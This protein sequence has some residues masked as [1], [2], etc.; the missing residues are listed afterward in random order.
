MVN[1]SSNR[2]N[3]SSLLRLQQ[4]NFK[5]LKLLLDIDLRAIILSTTQFIF[6]FSFYLFLHYFE[7]KKTII[8]LNLDIFSLPSP[9]IPNWS[10]VPEYSTIS[11][12]LFFFLSLLSVIHSFLFY[13]LPFLLNHWNNLIHYVSLC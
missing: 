6:L 11:L 5:G 2:T 10:L 1:K 12:S 4:K 8:T 3:W 7:K 9:I 13:F